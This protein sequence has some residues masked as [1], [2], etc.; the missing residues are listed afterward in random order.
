MYLRF[1]NHHVGSTKYR[2]IRLRILTTNSCDAKTFFFFSR[3]ITLCNMPHGQTENDS[4]SLRSIILLKPLF[5]CRV[6]DFIFFFFLD[7]FSLGK[8]RHKGERTVIFKFVHFKREILK[9]VIFFFI[10]YTEIIILNLTRNN[11]N[12]RG[13]CVCIHRSNYY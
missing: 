7:N 4:R 5:F 3:Q 12:S 13:L 6:S 2:V 10:A 1:R 11:S 8:S 9:N